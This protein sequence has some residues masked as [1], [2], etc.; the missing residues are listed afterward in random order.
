MKKTITILSMSLALSSTAC[1]EKEALPAPPLPGGGAESGASATS[2]ATSASGGSG[3]GSDGSSGGPTCSM[4]CPD[5]E[6]GTCA[7]HAEWSRGLVVWG[8][9]QSTDADGGSSGSFS[10]SDVH[11]DPTCATIGICQA[12]E[13]PSDID[14]YSADMLAEQMQ[15]CKAFTNA[16]LNSLGLTDSSVGQYGH[17]LVH[18][19]CTTG[20]LDKDYMGQHFSVNLDS[21]LD[22]CAGV[23]WKYEGSCSGPDCPDNPGGSGTDTGTSTGSGAGAEEYDCSSF[24][25]SNII[26]T[27]VGGRNVHEVDVVIRGGMPLAIASDPYPAMYY[28]ADGMVDITGTVHSIGGHSVMGTSGFGLMNL[29]EI[30]EVNGETD[31]TLFV[32]ELSDDLAPLLATPPEAALESVVK[33]L[34]GSTV[35]TYNVEWI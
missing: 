19:F 15:K 25:T 3:S 22:S 12:Y 8:V 33:V 26:T 24:H 29:D 7:G 9:W 34:R 27:N 5:D 16:D 20:R 13:S 10:V 14:A 30:Q 31:P 28:C 17:T 11:G 1:G 4:Q 2:G 23:E 35:W 6:S 21:S 32:N 18:H